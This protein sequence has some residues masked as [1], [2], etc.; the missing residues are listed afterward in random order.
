MQFVGSTFAS[1][2]STYPLPP[3]GATPPSRYN[4]HDAIHAAAYYLC[5]AGARDG[6]LRAAVYAYNH[7]DWYVN[8]VLDQA[9]RYRGAANTPPQGWVA[10]VHG[11][12]SSG[13]GVR[14]NDFHAGQDLAASIG[15]PILAAA[16]GTVLNAG[17]AAGY[18]LWVRLEHPDGTVTT[19]GHNNA[20]HV[21]VGEHVTAGQPIAEVGN[22]GESTGSHLHFQIT[23]GSGPVDPV[24][25]YRQKGARLCPG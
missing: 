1:V 7:A 3:G 25:F 9:A 8:K 17:P 24:G 16:D 11:R 14:G 2:A 12:C 18:G 4:P 15:T 19:Y 10:P 23:T 6:D 21:T 13:F 22:R 20:N 5:D